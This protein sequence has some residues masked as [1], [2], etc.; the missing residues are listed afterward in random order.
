VEA[1][2]Q[3]TR[4]WLAGQPGVDR[5]LISPRLRPLPRDATPMRG[6]DQAPPAPEWNLA[7]LGVPQVWASGIRGKGIVIGSSDS[8]VDVSHPAL[9]DSYRGGDDSWYD[10]WFGTTTPTD[11]NGHGTHTVGTAVG[12]D[13]IGWPRR[14]S[15]WPA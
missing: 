11:R 10:P 7:M 3:V 12:A 1:G 13:N 6:S 5:V 2:D 9:R 4:S 14:R 15:G 8:G